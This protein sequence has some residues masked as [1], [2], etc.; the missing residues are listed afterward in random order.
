[1]YVMGDFLIV[2]VRYSLREVVV[3]VSVLEMAL[4]GRRPRYVHTYFRL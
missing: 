1:M 2:H 4:I 3:T